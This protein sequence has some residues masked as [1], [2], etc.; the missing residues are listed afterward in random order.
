MIFDQMWGASGV[1]VY[2]KGYFEGHITPCNKKEMFF[3]FPST[4][5]S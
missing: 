1:N 5:N 4:Q 2:D 3:R